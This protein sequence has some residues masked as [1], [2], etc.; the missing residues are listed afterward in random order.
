DAPMATA[1]PGSPFDAIR[2]IYR[3]PTTLEL[4]HEAS[5]R[6]DQEDNAFTPPFEAASL[7]NSDREAA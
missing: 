3:P 6:V 4:R 7:I 1:T 5:P 2:P